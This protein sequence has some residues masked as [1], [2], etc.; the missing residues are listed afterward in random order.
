MDMKRHMLIYFFHIHV[1]GYRKVIILKVV[2]GMI[3]GRP[4]Q[5]FQKTTM[6]SKYSMFD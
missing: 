4:Y 1:G 5:G 3:H 2:F 6:L